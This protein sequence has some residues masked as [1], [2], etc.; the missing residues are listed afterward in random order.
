MAAADTIQP[1]LANLMRTVKSSAGVQ[2]QNMRSYAEEN[3]SS[4]QR[5]LKDIHRVFSSNSRNSSHINSLLEENSAEVQRQSGK[6]DSTNNLL[7]QTL[8]IQSVIASEMKSMNSG[9]RA[10][11]SSMRGNGGIGSAISGAMGADNWKKLAAAVGV[12]AGAAAVGSQLGGNNGG[13]GGNQN[14][15]PN[16]VAPGSHSEYLA[17]EDPK[18]QKILAAI[19]GGESSGNYTIENRSGKSSA[20]GA[21]QFIDKTWKAQASKVNG[22]S[23]YERAKDAPPEI[24]DRV[25]ANY[26]KDILRRTNGDVES[27]FRE[28]F[29]GS[30][31]AKTLKKE[32]QDANPGLTVDG[33]VADRMR[34]Y[35]GAQPRQQ[36]APQPQ[37]PQPQARQERQQQQQ[38]EE[39]PTLTRASL[40]VPQSP[41]RTRTSDPNPQQERIR[42]GGGN[43]REDQMKEAEIRKGPIDPNLKTLLQKAAETAGVD[44]RVKSG[45]QP[46]A[47]EGGKRTGST[48]HDR[49][50]AADLDL[51]IGNRKLSPNNPEDL[52]AFKQFVASAKQ[53]GAT[54]IG[55]G[56]GYMTPDASRIHVG[57]GSEAIWGAGGK[58]ANA[59]DWLKEAVGGV[60]TAAKP[61]GNLQPSANSNRSQAIEANARRSQQEQQSDPDAAGARPMIPDQNVMPNMQNAAFNPAIDGNIFGSHIYNPY[62]PR[63]SWPMQIISAFGGGL[64]RA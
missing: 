18:V 12:G 57:Y 7:Q 61:P 52:P 4:I 32:Q 8:S 37:V 38:Q 56:E 44:V 41:E 58:G 29:T 9:L 5:M 23:Q 17:S 31:T 49:G 42:E 40:P 11:A 39:R 6:L 30:P 20:S 21:Y 16:T 2:A 54:G 14:V 10:L 53:G 55:A 15:P 51:Y 48:R 33:V 13:A 3:N 27:V 62:S 47:A 28:W 34:R 35:N 1:A 43:V 25:A 63:M 26:V 19:R 22:A 64:L 60:S 45:G 36:Q 59:A 24:Q 46:T 50:M